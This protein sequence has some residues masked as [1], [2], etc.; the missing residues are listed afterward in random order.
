MPDV[1][2][3]WNETSRDGSGMIQWAAPV[4]AKCRYALRSEKRTDVNGD[5]FVSKAVVYSLSASLLIGSKVYLGRSGSPTPLPGADDVRSLS[6]N[7]SGS[8]ELKK[9]WL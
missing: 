5:D 4:V 2:T 1:V 7:P 3:I 9:A 8:G 6:Q